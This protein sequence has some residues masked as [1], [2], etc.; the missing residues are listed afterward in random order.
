LILLALSLTACAV[1]NPRG[2]LECSDDSQATGGPHIP[3]PDSDGP[4]ARLEGSYRKLDRPTY[5]Q[6]ALDAKVTGTVYVH[7]WVRA[8]GT[9]SDAAIEQTH[10]R[11]A[12][13][14]A[15]GVAERVR[16]WVF[17]APEDY[18]HAVA[19]EFIV[20]VRFSIKGYTP[21][22]TTEPV[23]PHAAK[24]RVLDTVTVEGK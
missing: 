2:A 3:P 23:S 18:G 14:L 21:P 24:A 20:P 13:T 22:T 9:V 1:S 11:S 6:V 10:P 15:D 19:S 7:V 16:T 5:P 17:N 4:M 8:D 12:M